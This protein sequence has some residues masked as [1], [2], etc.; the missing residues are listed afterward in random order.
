M[1]YLL[2]LNNQDSSFSELVISGI[3]EITLAIYNSSNL[4]LKSEGSDI[5]IPDNCREKESDEHRQQ[6]AATIAI[7]PIWKYLFP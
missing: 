3:V 1:C 5:E 6:P 4:E 7:I 2:D